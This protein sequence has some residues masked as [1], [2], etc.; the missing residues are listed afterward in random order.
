MK[1]YMNR[2]VMLGPWGGGNNATMALLS[3]F[4]QDEDQFL[5]ENSLRDTNVALVMGLLRENAHPGLTDILHLKS[6]WNLKFKIVLRV[7][8]CDARKGTWDVDKQWIGASQF[9][10][11]TIFVSEWMR[12]YYLSKGWACKNNVVIVNGVDHAIFKPFHGKITGEKTKIVTHHWSDNPMK[13]EDYYVK[14]DE[15]VGKNSDRYEY[16]FIGRTKAKLNYTMVVPPLWGRELGAALSMN[17]ICVNASRFDPGPNS[18]IE[19]IACGLPTYVH[20][21]GG[22]GFEF[23][24]PEHS[25]SSWEELEYMLESGVRKPNNF[26]P[27]TW[28]EF[29][30]DVLDFVKRVHDAG[31]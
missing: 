31:A 17:H 5:P 9:V 25:F 3:V 6:K 16:T 26:Q 19:S 27:R 12:D 1:V 4:P 29:S 8:D 2:S 22:G 30:S 13:G 15:F 20:V 24:G 28:E 7:N 21:D 10:D 23:A 14:L 18:V 11:G